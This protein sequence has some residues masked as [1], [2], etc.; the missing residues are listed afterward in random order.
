MVRVTVPGGRVKELEISGE[1]SAE[2]LLKT[3]GLNPSEFLV[4]KDK[5]IATPE[6]E[7]VRND[8]EIELVRVVHGG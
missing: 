3:L 1:L 7:R 6:C 2:E 4:V 5:R 8:D